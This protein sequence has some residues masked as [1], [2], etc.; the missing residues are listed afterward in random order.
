[1]HLSSDLSPHHESYDGFAIISSHAGV[2]VT[3]IQ[4]IH[5]LGADL[6]ETYLNAWD[7]WPENQH[8]CQRQV[9]VDCSV[10]IVPAFRVSS[11]SVP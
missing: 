8:T 10:Q 6:E 11:K 5:F 3:T 1:M 4:G 2:K 9:C 7:F